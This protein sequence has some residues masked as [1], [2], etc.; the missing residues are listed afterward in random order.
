MALGASSRDVFREVL[1]EGMQLTAVGTALGLVAALLSTRFLAGLLFA[2]TP[3]DPL[4]FV[5]ITAM[6]A[7]T[8]FLACFIPARR[9]TSVDATTALRSE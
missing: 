2:V 5:S 1:R 3:T 8:S 6:I 4:T 7:A 9:A